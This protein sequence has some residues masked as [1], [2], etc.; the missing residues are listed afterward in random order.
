MKVEV[1]HENSNH[2]NHEPCMDIS[3][4]WNDEVVRFLDEMPREL[5]RTVASLR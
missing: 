3:L 4:R 1:S 5:F 2:S